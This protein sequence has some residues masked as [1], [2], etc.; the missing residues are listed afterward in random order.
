MANPSRRLSLPHDVSLA[1]VGRID[2]TIKAL[3]NL[4]EKAKAGNIDFTGAEVDC[5]NT[6]FHL[7]CRLLE[8]EGSA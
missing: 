7:A 2:L 5:V 1:F 4:R 3:E 8:Q 6:R